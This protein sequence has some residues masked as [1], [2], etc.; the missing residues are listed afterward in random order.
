[1]D[2]A[3]LDQLAAED[4]EERQGALARWQAAGSGAVAALVAGLEHPHWR[5]RAAAAG[6]LD[7]VADERCA[8]P[9]TRAL[10]DPVAAVRRNAVHAIGCQRCKPAPLALDTVAELID[11]AIRDPSIRVRRAAAHQLGCQRP[12]GRAAEALRGILAGSRDAKL[13]GIAR[14]ALGVQERAPLG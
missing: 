8:E 12:D 5:V 1:M 2:P 11:R 4:R 6:L 10:R 14:W 7:H 3:G 13:L 9:L